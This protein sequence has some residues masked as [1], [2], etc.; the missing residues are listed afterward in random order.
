MKIKKDVYP[1]LETKYPLMFL[2]EK[3][4]LEDMQTYIL[5]PNEW[6]YILQ[7][8]WVIGFREGWKREEGCPEPESPVTPDNDWQ[9]FDDPPFHGKIRVVETDD[10][11]TDS[12]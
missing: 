5:Q 9:D 6:Q 10:E 11:E 3:S 1:P 8:A 7:C 4:L 2:A 12:K